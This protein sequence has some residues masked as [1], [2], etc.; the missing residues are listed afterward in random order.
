M[1]FLVF[2]C[3][4]LFVML[5]ICLLCPL[6][7]LVFT[8]YPLP[9]NVY[10][11]L[12]LS[13]I[14]VYFFVYFFSWISLVF[15]LCL[16]CVSAIP[17]FSWLFLLCVSLSHFLVPK[18]CL[19]LVL[20]VSLQFFHFVSDSLCSPRSGSSFTVL[21]FV[22]LCHMMCA[23][24]SFLV[25]PI[26]LFL[27]CCELWFFVFPYLSYWFHI[28][29]FSHSA[30]PSTFSTHYLKF[31]CLLGHFL[32]ILSCFVSL[33][34]FLSVFCPALSQCLFFS[35][36][37]FPALSQCLFFSFF[38]LLCL[39]VSLLFVIFPF[40][41]SSL[42]SCFSSAFPL[43]LT[44]EYFSLFV[45]LWFPLFDFMQSSIL[46]YFCAFVWS[47]VCLCDKGAS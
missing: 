47:C 45:S 26:P 46:A 38:F 21:P 23:F 7:Y 15:L 43:L 9:L 36:F 33:S 13:L 25:L 2:F 41:H 6:L 24:C 1:Y 8:S 37:F 32:S 5:L 29:P 3:C 40:Q 27:F 44:F 28:S 22:S 39:S 18:S 17:W 4:L 42:F 34:L 11:C 10:L 16:K 14:S 31:L 19:C 12:P 30:F 20:D 35:V